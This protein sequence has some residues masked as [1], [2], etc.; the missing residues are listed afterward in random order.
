VNVYKYVVSLNSKNNGE[1]STE[2][3]LYKKAEAKHLLI[4]KIERALRERAFDCPLNMY[5]NIFP[6]EVRKYEKCDIH[7][8]LKCPAIC[9]YTKCD[10]NCDN[11][12]L[13]QKYYDPK[14]KIYRLLKNAELDKT[15]FIK[16]FAEYE[17]EYAKKQ[18]K[19]M[20]ILQPVYTLNDILNYV[21]N[22]YT[23]EKR[24]L[25]DDFFVYRALNDLIPHTQNEFNNFR[26]SII[27]KNNIQ[28]YIIYRNKY[29]IFQPFTQ[30]ED[31]P[32]YYRIHNNE[33]TDKQ[34]SLYNYLKTNVEYNK[35]KG[36]A[37]TNNISEEV[38]NNLYNYDDTYEYYDMRP[39][40]EYVGIIDKELSRG[41]NKRFDELK[42]VFKIRPKLKKIDGKKRGTG[43]HS[44]SGSVCST[45]K[46]KSYLLKIAKKLDLNVKK[47]N[48]RDNI[49]DF[50][51]DELLLR[52]K[53]STKKEKNKF[54]YIRIPSN[55]PKYP[56]PYNLE[57]RVNS[58]INIIKKEIKYSIDISSK[59]V[60]SKKTNLPIYYIII[61]DTDNMKYY[62]D[63]LQKYNAIKKKNTWEI[64][65]E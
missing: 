24:E 38:D 10:Y 6:E 52:E 32:M 47:N 63:F 18:I 61:Q 1:L 17:I 30:N 48:T 7:G 4:K 41:K 12:K 50:I 9:D 56:F 43:I 11:I 16:G 42:D 25:F 58:I 40:Y 28:G 60:I 62:K 31:V 27:D 26:D 53:Y 34:L 57:D 36:V 2:E 8:E 59:S 22:S 55:H 51:R 49:C 65:I 29:Y 45:S 54:T 5:G 44:I 46:A 39:E 14:R 15:T 3:I 37:D 64:K 20:Y 21:K 19:N 23:P 13:N 33:F 35:L